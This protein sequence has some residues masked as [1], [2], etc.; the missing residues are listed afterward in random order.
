M[1][2]AAANRG[3]KGAR[4]SGGGFYKAEA[5]FGEYALPD[6]FLNLEITTIKIHSP[7]LQFSTDGT[8]STLTLS[9]SIIP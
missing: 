5:L 2:G 7:L 9:K 8:A 1:E 4:S 6:I 3:I